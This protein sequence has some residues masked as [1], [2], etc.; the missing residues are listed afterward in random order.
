M[1]SIEQAHEDYQAGRKQRAEATCRQLLTRE[2]NNDR[3]LHLLGIMALE[4]RQDAMAA[5]LFMRALDNAPHKAAYYVNLAT[6]LH[7]LGKLPEAVDV[8]GLALS[9]DPNL[10]EAHFNLARVLSD[11]GDEAGSFSAVE[12]AAQLS[13]NR[14][15]IQLEFAR[16]LN[17]RGEF[18]RSIESY[19]KAIELEPGA[20]DSRVE[21]ASVLRTQRHYDE[22]VTAAR[23][24]V[25]LSPRLL[26]A[27]IELGKSLLSLQR[28]GEA[29]QA[30]RRAALL[31][32]SSAEAHA[33]LGFALEAVGRVPE[34]IESMQ[35]SL[36]LDP[37]DHSMLSNIIFLRPFVPGTSAQSL[38][39][40]AKSWDQVFGQPSS[41]ALP[42][43][44]N[45]ADPERRLRVGY[46]SGYFYD[47]CQ[48]F[49]TVPLLEHHDRRAVE[50]YCYSATSR[51][52]SIT[53][54]ISRLADVWRDVSR[55]GDAQL[56]RAIRDDRV[57]ILVDLTMHMGNSKLKAFAE[58]PAPVQICWLA[59]PG[60]TGLSAMDYRITDRYLDP[61]ES[62]DWP[63][64]ERS[65]VLPDSFWCYDP[66]T[67]DV[68]PGPLPAAQRG[69]VTFGCLNHVRK[70]NEAT[71]RLW[72]D[73]LNQVRDS[74]LLLHAPAL[75]S[76]SGIGEIL[77]RFGVRADRVTFAGRLP[78]LEYLQLYRQIDIG[79][80]T[81]PCQG[82]TTSLDALWMGVPV[83]SLL[84]PLLVG[85][86]A[87]T[88]A[89]NLELGELVH[90][91][92]EGF[93]QAAVQLAS[94]VAKLQGLRSNLR[95]RMKACPLMDAH[96]FARNMEA[97]YRSA[98]R[99]RCEGNT[100]D[101]SPL[102]ISPWTADEP[103]L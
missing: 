23:K 34:A 68:E 31:D 12:R 37:S 21:L 78:R 76:R 65:L 93:V 43:C 80:D 54:K 17:R 11:L 91:T 79:L 51:P 75:E 39:D 94:D 82:H 9:T 57:D 61:P 56:A 26:G 48:S 41:I 87:I 66:L 69:C 70:V 101:R 67:S 32:P 84:S 98:W 58:R 55:L 8:L 99:L 16:R 1:V 96:R 72:A 62:N 14:S 100:G 60:T 2:P 28:E 3:A 50:V 86:A 103:V 15:E 47:H 36:T 19:R 33:N 92:N 6:A 38:L 27:H 46:V 95:S 59:Y 44:E 52:D 7:R 13:S 20:A 29:I 83:V 22:A 81:F 85:R 42:A 10:A 74:R 97:A 45:D 24:A 77:E 64:S 102:M 25:E 88:L 63:Y 49:F 53:Q 71:L 30:L 4:V 89:A 35:R 73:I 40:E 5:Q 18:E 90:E